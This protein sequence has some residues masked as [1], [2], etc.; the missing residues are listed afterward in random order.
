VN[1]DAIREQFASQGINS[2][3]EL[4]SQIEKWTHIM[5]AGPATIPGYQ[6]FPRMPPEAWLHVK[7]I[8]DTNGAMMLTDVSGVDKNGTSFAR[9]QYASVSPEAKEAVFNSLARIWEHLH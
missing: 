3:E 4:K 7:K 6:D 5:P 9:G 1:A 2:L 8:L